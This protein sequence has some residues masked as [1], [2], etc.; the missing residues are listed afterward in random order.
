MATFCAIFCAIVTSL[1]IG[2]SVSLKTVVGSFAGVVGQFLLFG[3]QAVISTSWL[4]PLRANG[5]V[6]EFDG[7]YIFEEMPHPST[8]AIQFLLLITTFPLRFYKNL[9]KMGDN[10]RRAVQDI[11]LGADDVPIAIPADVVAVA[12]AENRFI[13][14]GRPVIP[15]RQNVRSIIASMPRVWGQSS[16]VHGRIVGGNQFQFI[17]P[18]EESLATVMRRGP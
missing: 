3:R 9:A 18:S 6:Y 15:R 4:I 17:F 10:L 14:M 8:L 13:L 5:T 1:W 16:L 12:A 2:F 7:D 11:D